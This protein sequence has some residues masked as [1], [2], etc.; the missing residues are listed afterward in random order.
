M[1]GSQMAQLWKTENTLELEKEKAEYLLDK[2]AKMLEF[3]ECFRMIAGEY[4]TK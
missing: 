4:E 3:S 1:K 2:K